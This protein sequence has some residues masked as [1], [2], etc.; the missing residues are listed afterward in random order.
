MFDV[1]CRPQ[2]RWPAGGR[3]GPASHRPV[4]GPRPGLS[5]AGLALTGPARRGQPGPAAAEPRWPLP[6]LG[7]ELLH[8]V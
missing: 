6:A 4:T 8:Q 1:S 3:R 2:G 5:P 7:L